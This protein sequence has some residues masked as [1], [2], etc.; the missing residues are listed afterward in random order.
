MAK[1]THAQ[2]VIL[3]AAAQ[4]D[5]CGVELPANVQGEAARKI[6]DKLIR[7]GLLEE[8]GAGGSLPVWRRDD[9]SGAIALRITSAGL[10]AI[11]AADE[12]TAAPEENRGRLA[13]TGEVARS[14]PRSH[15]PS[16]KQISVSAQKS[17]HKRHRH[18]PGKAKTQTGS[19]HDSRPGSK[20]ARGA[21]NYRD[22]GCDV[23]ISYAPCPIRP[24]SED[25]RR[26]AHRDYWLAERRPEE[27]LL[28]EWAKGESEPTKYWLSTLPQ[29]IAFRDLVDAAKLR[30][31]IERDYQELKQEVGLGH[32]EGRGWRGFHHHATLCIAAYGFLISERGRIPPSADRSSRPLPGPAVPNRDRP[33]QSAAAARTP[34]PKLDRHHAPTHHRRSGQNAAAMS[35]LRSANRKTI[36]P[37]KFLTQ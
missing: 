3:S 26:M 7:A 16:R 29:D 5:D 20:Q 27:W 17:A 14:A 8:V 2:L 31:R 6:V 1:L 11:D 36:T 34:Y 15:R 23:T 24:M 28:I 19:L 10:A 21:W 25:V 33:R 22:L 18:R 9:E 32:F 4:R 37:Q 30:W 12:A 13:S 35:L